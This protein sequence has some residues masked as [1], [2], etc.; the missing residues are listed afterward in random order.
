MIDQCQNWTHHYDYNYTQALLSVLSC[1][2]QVGV[3][4]VLVRVN[5][6]GD[7]LL[8]DLAGLHCSLVL[9]HIDLIAKLVV[10][11]N[12]PEG[13]ADRLTEALHVS[14]QS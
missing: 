14:A 13:R 11:D 5:H 2:L 9:A 8:I 12:S 4:P 6:E 1:N 7:P 3:L 10:E